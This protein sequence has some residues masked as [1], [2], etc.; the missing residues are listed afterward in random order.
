M[1]NM[2]YKVN[3]K[4]V[5]INVV[6]NITKKTKKRY[7]KVV[8]STEKIIQNKERYTKN[9]IMKNTKIL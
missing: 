6:K 7:W 1:V 5:I 3:V 2:D 4:D 9:N 8:K